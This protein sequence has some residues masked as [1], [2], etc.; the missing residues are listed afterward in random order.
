MVVGPGKP[1]LVQISRPSS[2]HNLVRADSNHALPS[3][4]FHQPPSTPDRDRNEV[5]VFSPDTSGCETPITDLSSSG[6]HEAFLKKERPQLTIRTTNLSAVPE[7]SSS[8]QRPTRCTYTGDTA[9]TFQTSKLADPFDSSPSARSSCSSYSSAMPGSS[10]PQQL[11]EPDSRREA[12]YQRPGVKRTASGPRKYQL[13]KVLTAATKA[14]AALTE[15]R[16]NLQA[17]E[18]QPFQN[19]SPSRDTELLDALRSIFTATN[20][21]ALSELAAWVVLNHYFTS[22]LESPA[23]DLNS[24]GYNGFKQTSSPF[25]KNE[26]SPTLASDS[27]WDK[28]TNLSSDPVRPLPSAVPSKAQ[29][30]LGMGFR[31]SMSTVT[32]PR[33]LI[34]ELARLEDRAH[35]VHD[36][37]QVVGRKLVGNLVGDQAA[38]NLWDAAKVVA[39][40]VFQRV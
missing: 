5:S 11:W 12:L 38:K 14:L 4:H 34:A 7:R 29:Q 36:S 2:S 10:D 33:G 13:A 23:E 31:S 19:G 30:V 26:W 35:F 16:F 20:P 9:D 32:L 15:R 28:I 1:K 25:E 24:M 27:Y 6:F 17:T 37:I 39:G 22:V 8:L 3:H 21:S 18:L 40:F